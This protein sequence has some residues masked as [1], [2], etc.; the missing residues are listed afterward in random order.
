MLD[1]FGGGASVEYFRKDERKDPLGMR[2]EIRGARRAEAL[3]EEVR[4]FMAVVV[5]VVVGG[6]RGNLR[7]QS[8]FIGQERRL[9]Q[10][11]GH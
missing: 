9:G 4:V 8:K 6:K 3:K 5:R 2:A 1:D 11:H 7:Y 10:V